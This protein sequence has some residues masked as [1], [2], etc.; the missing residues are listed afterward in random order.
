MN[1]SIIPLILQRIMAAVAVVFGIVTIIAGSRVLTGTDPGYTVFQPLLVYNTLM[2]VAY[3]AG[4]LMIWRNI[5]R[6]KYVAAS[7][8]TLNLIVLGGIAYLY[9]VSDGVA[10]DSLRA[11]TLRTVVWLVLLLGSMWLGRGKV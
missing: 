4:G 2:G 10:V 7:I 11:M 8:F 6:G 5:R 3:I 1:Q 9:F